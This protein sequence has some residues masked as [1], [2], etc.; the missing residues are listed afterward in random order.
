MNEIN[1]TIDGKSCAGRPD[2]T[3]LAC[4]ERHGVSIPAICHA[5]G[6][7]HNT[8]CFVCIV[9]EVRSGRMLPSCS[10]KIHEGLAVESATPEVE[11]MRRMS[12]NLLLSEHQ[13]DC[14]A[15]CTNACPAEANVEEYVRAGRRGDHLAALQIIK[16]R[17]PLPMSIGRVCPRFC[18]KECRRNVVDKQPVAINDFKRLAADLHYDS[19]M[20][21]LPPLGKRKVAIVGAGPAGFAA[22]YFL[23]KNGVASELFEARM[24]GGGMLRYGIPEYRLPKGILDK[25]LA[26]FDKMGGIKVH[27]GRELGRNLTMAELDRGYDAVCVTL[28][29]WHATELGVDGDQLAAPGIVWLEKIAKEGWRGSN[30]GKVVVIGGGNTAMDCVRTSVR[31]GSAEVVCCYRRSN[32]E[33]P[34]EKIEIEEAKEEGV[35]FMFLTAPVKLE[36]RGGRKLLTCIKMT[37]GEPDASGRRRPVPVKGSE[38]TIEADLVISAV[39]QK[40]KAPSGIALNKW[41]DVAVDKADNRVGGKM[42]AAGDCVSGPASVVE[43]VAGAR[44]AALGIVAWLEGKKFEA[45][46]EINVSRGRWQH[47][48][49]KEMVFLNDPPKNQREKQTL[50]PL[51]ARKK[52]FAE[53]AE[54]FSAQMLE[55][56]GSRCVECSCTE[57]HDCK[58]KTHAEEYRA[59]P[60]AL[61]AAKAPLQYDIRHPK[62]LL[63]RGKCVKCGV[64]IKVCK[65]VVGKSLLGFKGRGSY[66]V[67]GT[68]FDRP[69]ESSCG[70]CGKCVAQCPV[71]ALAW[72]YKA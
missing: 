13:G 65:E 66:T 58:L 71:G 68:A 61:K 60:T 21:E 44:K 26:H 22:A 52:S 30:P 12:L 40:T 9:K 3:I 16:E 62:I 8:S 25:E 5:A 49:A 54:T 29:S 53:V 63:D 20:E 42:F 4:A 15:P 36:E 67:V 57:K 55:R 37:L 2:E 59:S 72:R 35:D 24:Q 38:F 32:E 47:L 51:S 7:T 27:Y 19:Y 14:E 56:E 41:G 39:G 70:D 45:P 34:A 46:Y 11:A 69:L 31:L 17:I 33:M 10:Y 18:E 64:C 1:I 50:I 23:R 48:A 43:A 6:I 28:G